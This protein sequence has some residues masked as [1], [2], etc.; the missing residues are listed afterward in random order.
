[1]PIVSLSLGGR[2]GYF[3][4]PLGEGEGGVEAPEG[5]GGSVFLLKSPGR[6]GLQEGRGR[7][8]GRVSAANWG[9]FWGGGGGRG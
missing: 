5:G 2:F 7:G 4:F 8:A 6:G 3:L 1:M 9:I